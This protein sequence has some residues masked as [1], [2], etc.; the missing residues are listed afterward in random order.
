MGNTLGLGP[1][2]LGRIVTEAVAGLRKFGG[3]PQCVV[4]DNYVHWCMLKPESVVGLPVKVREWANGNIHV[5]S[6]DD[7]DRREPAMTQHS[8]AGDGQ[9]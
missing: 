9:T 3:K 6:T 7:F 8:G 5:M 4:M 2:D 1:R